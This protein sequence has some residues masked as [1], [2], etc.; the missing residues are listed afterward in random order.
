MSKLITFRISEERM[1]RLDSLVAGGRYPTRAAA[2]TAA[3]D[4]LL[5]EERERAI[6]RA[7]VD[8]YTRSPPTASEGAYAWAAG[9]RSIASEPW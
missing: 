3:L 7:I 8:G 1:E 4:R 2:M 5:D 9:R 6:D